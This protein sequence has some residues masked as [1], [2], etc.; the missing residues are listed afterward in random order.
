MDSYELQLSLDEINLLLSTLG[1]LP[2]NKSMSLI[3]KIQQQVNPQLS[4]NHNNTRT[5]Y[6]DWRGYSFNFDYCFTCH[7]C[8]I[9]QKA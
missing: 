9:V 4:S 7:F 1:E 6:C 3:L 8:S 2:A 5:F